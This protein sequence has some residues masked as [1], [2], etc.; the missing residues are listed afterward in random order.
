M[1]ESAVTIGF[2]GR[3]H[4]RKDLL[5]LID[6]FAT[7]LATVPNA[8]LLLIAAADDQISKDYEAEVRARIESLGVGDRVIVDSGAV[9]D[10]PG[11]YRAMSSTVYAAPVDYLPM[12]ILESLA[13]GVPVINASEGGPREAVIDDQSGIQ[14]PGG[15]SDALA[16]NIIQLLS[17]QDDLSRLGKGARD[18]ALAEFDS[19]AFA[20][21]I[22][23]IYM[24]MVPQLTYSGLS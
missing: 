4:P 2:V 1:S 13:S 23:S 10:L 7:V 12:A 9:A 5:M 8:V 17:S 16:S 11:I 21:D 20:R 6:A 3:M 22:E 15:S 24:E 19:K 18:R 14:V